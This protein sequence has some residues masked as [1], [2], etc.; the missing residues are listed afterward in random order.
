MSQSQV[1]WSASGRQSTSRI[2][3][4]EKEGVD[5]HP[6]S[7]HEVDLEKGIALNHAELIRTDSGMPWA[8]PKSEKEEEN[9]SR[10]EK[11]E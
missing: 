3:V 10:D 8:R 9:K 1:R 11:G 7:Q 4:S 6:S 2:A 5:V